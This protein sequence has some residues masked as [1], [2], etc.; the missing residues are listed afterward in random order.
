MVQ[1]VRLHASTAGGTGS[2]PGQET[3]IPHASQT[4]NKKTC[5][6]LNEKARQV[7]SPNYMQLEREKKKVVKENN[8]RRQHLSWL[9]KQS[10]KCPG[11]GLWKGEKQGG[12]TIRSR[13]GGREKE[14]K[15]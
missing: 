12:L 3:K 5:S 10:P 13:R 15:V 9:L 6:Q 14:T 1:W 11:P 8:Q 7:K 4:K 2:I